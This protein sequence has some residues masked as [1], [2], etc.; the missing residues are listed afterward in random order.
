M[1]QVGLQRLVCKRRTFKGP[2]TSTRGIDMV[3]EKTHDMGQEDEFSEYEEPSEGSSYSL[4]SSSC[5]L[6]AASL[7]P[8]IPLQ[9]Y[10]QGPAN[11]TICELLYSMLR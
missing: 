8:C 5:L 11:H 9:G 4:S 1:E 10:L 6:S 2:G 3:S 7:I